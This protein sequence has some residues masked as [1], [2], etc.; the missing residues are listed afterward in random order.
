MLNDK[1]RALI[2][3]AIELLDEADALV[4]EAL[5]ATDACYDTHCAI[6]DVIGDLEADYLEAEIG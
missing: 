5:G 6:Q 3:K 4:Q 2:A 1:Q